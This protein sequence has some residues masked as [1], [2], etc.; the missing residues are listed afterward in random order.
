MILTVLAVVL[1]AG[2]AVGG[3]LYYLQQQEHADK[4][5]AET[6]PEDTAE[7][8]DEDA[9]DGVLSDLD[10]DDVRRGVVAALDWFTDAVAWITDATAGTPAKRARLRVV[11]GIAF[12]VAVVGAFAATALL[13][14]GLVAGVAFVGALILGA[15]VPLGGIPMLK[16]GFPLGGTVAPLLAILGQYV[17]GRGAVVR[18]EDGGYEWHRLA[19]TETGYAVTLDDSTTIPVSGNRG[20][21]YRFG[22]RPLAILEEKGQN[23]EQFTVR[24]EPPETAAE[25]TRE[26]RAG[27][28]VHHP[29]KLQPDSLLV[30]LKHLAQPASGS[31][32]PHLARRGREKALEEAGGQQA[33][34]TFWLM[35]LTGGLAIIGFV[36]GYGA[37]LL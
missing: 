2:G 10:A 26:R 3:A 12:G 6:E 17:L 32:G 33:I 7:T 37:L 22:G 18:R 24:E 23:V 19:E 13:L 35:I 30:S 34:S 1:V 8:E 9:T 36:M 14:N 21:L 31:A 11:V 25:S 27:M 15:G 20:D 29:E 4:D 5:T 16:D 28:D